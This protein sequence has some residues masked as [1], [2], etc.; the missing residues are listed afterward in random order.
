MTELKSKRDAANNEVLF[1]ADIVE[2]LIAGNARIPR[3]RRSTIK[4]TKLRWSDMKPQKRLTTALSL[5]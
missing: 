2:K 4:S 5:R 1:L 3:I